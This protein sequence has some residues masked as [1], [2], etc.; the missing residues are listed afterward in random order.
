MEI[1]FIAF[2][3]FGVK[4]MCTQVKTK[5]ITIT[6]DPGIAE[7]VDSFPL[8]RIERYSLAAKYEKKIR[9]SCKESDVIISTHYHYDHH[10]PEESKEMYGDKVLLIKDPKNKINISQKKRGKEFLETVKKLPKKIAVADGK[11][12]KFGKTSIIFTKPLWHGVEN[13]KLGYVIGVRIVDGNKRDSIFFSSDLNGI[14]VNKYV[15]TILE[16]DSTVLILDGPPTYLLGYIMSYRNL[17][18]SNE[19]IIKIVKKSKAK[20]IILDHHL[21][22]DYRFKGLM[23]PVYEKVEGLGKRVLTAAEFLGKKPKVLEGYEKNG[24]TRWKKWQ[25]FSLNELRKFVKKIKKE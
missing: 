22:R 10:I 11:I 25:T 4:S 23:N 17:L 7:E 21:P 20:L 1:K 18:R 8:S 9:K 15:K 16:N 24:S 19:N 6:I 3:S 2:D 5:D 14:E 13:S 12:F